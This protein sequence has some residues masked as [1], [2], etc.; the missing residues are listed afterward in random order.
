MII[1]LDNGHAKSTKGKRSPDGTFYEYEFNR[2][3]VK[4]I[5]ESL[6][7][8]KIDFH[9]ITPELELDVPLS[10]RAN[11]VNNYCSIYGAGNCLLISVHANAA[12]NGS[13]WMTGRGWSVYT[14]KGQTNSD[15][16][17]TLI[18]KE[19]EKII[20]TLGSK[21]RADYSDGDPDWEENFT[22]LY[23]AKCP[24]ILTENLFY[25]SRSDLKILQ[26]EA[27]RQAIADIHT[28]FIKQINPD[29]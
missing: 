3:I 9:I 10:E 21:M 26:S 12:G 1:L 13:Q 11:R 14:T 16:Y 22:L 25:D 28:N 18:Y 6:T 24:A 8:N 4:R 23:K 15:K 2:D 29:Q 5:S 17:A 27:G 20:P 19:A 7:K